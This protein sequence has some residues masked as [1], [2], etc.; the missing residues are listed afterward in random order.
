MGVWN[1]LKA[2]YRELTRDQ[3]DQ[4]GL[5]QPP[6]AAG[7]VVSQQTALTV[8][9]YWNG[10]NV[11]AG[12]I[13]VLDRFLYKRLGDDDR[14]RATAHPV[15]RVVHDAPNEYM[16][17]QVFWQTIVAHALSWG[18]GYAEIEWDNAMRF[19]AL[20]PIAPDCIEPKVEVLTDAA[21]R[22]SCWLY[23]LY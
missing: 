15:Y 6:T 10:I 17:P 1:R 5:S 21:G 23:Y 20:W 18:G 16:T 12:D 2:A 11:I 22:K 19:I 9:A 13:G 7:V 4:L 8:S 3:F 14:E